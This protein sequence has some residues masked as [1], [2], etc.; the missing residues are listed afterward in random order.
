MISP[1]D[2]SEFHSRTYLKYLTRFL[3]YFSRHFSWYSF[4]NTSRRFFWI[5]TGISQDSNNPG[6]FQ[7]DATKFLS[8]INLH[9]F[10][11]YGYQSPPQD[12][13]RS[14]S[15]V[16]HKERSPQEFLSQNR[17]E[18]QSRNFSQCFSL[19][20]LL[21]A[22]SRFISVSVRLGMSPEDVPGISP[23]LSTGDFPGISTTAPLRI[24]SGDFHELP[25]GTRDFFSVL[26]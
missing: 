15:Y 14:S 12:F 7:G 26:Y 21:N 6:F 25:V 24:C 16:L 8:R 2:S 3:P 5:P 11:R 10:S 9:R 18:M 13:S 23:K 4:L 1:V 17:S 19:E 22:Y 20:F